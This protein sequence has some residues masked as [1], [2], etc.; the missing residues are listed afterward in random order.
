MQYRDMRYAA[1]Y[2]VDARVGERRVRLTVVNVASGGI[3]VAGLENVSGAQAGSK[4]VVNLLDRL[5][6][7]TI[8]WKSNTLAGLRFDLPL[9]PRDIAVV[10]HAVGTWAE[11]EAGW[12]SRELS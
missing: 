12:A 4:V 5:I 6:N 8:V 11:A 3:R 10:R 2:P 7:A 9:S 1:R